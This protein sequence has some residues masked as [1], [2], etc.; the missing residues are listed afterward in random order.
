MIADD[1]RLTLGS[2][3]SVGASVTLR[4]GTFRG[5]DDSRET[6]RMIH[7]AGRVTGAF[8]L[9]GGAL[10]SETYLGGVATHG[11]LLPQQFVYLGGPVIGPGYDYHQFVG[12]AG[13]SQRIEWKREVSAIP[14]PL[15]RF[16]STPVVTAIIP[17]ANAVWI[18]GD[19][20]RGAV[21]RGVFPSLGA[22]LELFSGALRA[23]V[24][25]GLRRGR[26]TFAVDASRALWSIL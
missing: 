17:F 9:V 4:A 5:D 1:A 7:A 8:P 20:A 11:P 12:T 23:D 15:G 26:W 19:S 13:A 18:H 16:G 24:A 25:R 22:G 21:E 6:S 10:V 14:F 3:G 2:A